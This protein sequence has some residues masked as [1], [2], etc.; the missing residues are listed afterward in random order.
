MI[1]IATPDDIDSLVKFGVQALDEHAYKGLVLSKARIRE[2]A[3]ECVSSPSHF[4]WVSTERGVIVA[5]LSALVSEQMFHDRKQANVIQ[6]YSTKPGEGVKLLR[7][8]LHWARGRRAIK[9]ISTTK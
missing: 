6:F 8:F 2:V 1:R 5:A 3:I 4:C 9:V 7:H